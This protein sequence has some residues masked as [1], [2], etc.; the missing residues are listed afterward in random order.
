MPVDFNFLTSKQKKVYTAIETY[1]KSKGIPPTVR[2]IGEMVGEKTPGA[3]QGILNRLEQKGVIKRQLGAARS[4][5]L[6]SDTS[7][8]MKPVYLP[9]IKKI[10]R[11]NIDN[12]LN[13][14]NISKQHPISPD[15]LPSG[16]DYF[17]IN[18]PDNSL[19]DSGIKYEDLLI[20]CRDCQ[21][22]DNDVVL[23]LYES[24]VLLRRYF[25]SESPNSITLKA[26]SNLLDRESFDKNEITIVG[27]LA[28]KFTKY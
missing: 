16:K 12:L 18:C 25:A 9:E 27:K 26:D 15:L 19:A 23:V 11:R 28:G 4:V 10:G 6:V 13:M 2:E 21:P 17:I 14:Y 20:I 5:Q 3:V 22:K 24:H 7:Q 8:Y 1:I